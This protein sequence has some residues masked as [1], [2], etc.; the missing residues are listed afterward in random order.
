MAKDSNSINTRKDPLR[1]G[2]TKKKSYVMMGVARYLRDNG[3]SMARQCFEGGK[4]MNGNP[5]SYAASVGTIANV[6][7][8]RSDFYI[9]THQRN[10]HLWM[11]RLDSELLQ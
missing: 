1:I 4:L 11:V 8:Q 3:P 6:M 9:H 2:K 10:G 5:I 7:K